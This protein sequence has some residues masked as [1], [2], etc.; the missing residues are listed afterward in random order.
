MLLHWTFALGFTSA[1]AQWTWTGLVGKH[2]PGFHKK[3]QLRFVGGQISCPR[4]RLSF[5]LKK[6]ISTDW[7]IHGHRYALAWVKFFFQTRLR[8]Y[9]RI[10]MR[11]NEK[12][13]E[14]ISPCVLSPSECSTFPGNHNN[15]PPPP[16]RDTEGKN[17]SRPG[18]GGGRFRN[19][20]ASFKD[21]QK[22]LPTH[23][24]AY[25]WS[26]FWRAFTPT[27]TWWRRRRVK[28]LRISM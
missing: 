27:H 7:W 28:N 22:M 6:F 21:S 17:G 20:F 1:G 19:V 23:S 15:Y 5:I 18:G 26:I 12:K 14:E 9:F 8:A 4:K 2:C 13:G 3:T 16:P 11:E 25:I 10:W 24:H